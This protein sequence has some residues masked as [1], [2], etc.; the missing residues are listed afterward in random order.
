MGLIS[1][2]SSRTYRFP[3]KRPLKKSNMVI[4][5]SNKMLKK[6]NA[7][8]SPIETQIGQAVLDIQNNAEAS[9]K[10]QLMQLH[11]VGAKEFDVGGRNAI[12]ISVPAPQVPA[13]RKIQEKLVRELEKKFSNKHV[14]IVG[15]RKI[16]PE[17]KRKASANCYKQKRPISRSIKQVHEN[18]LE[19][20]V[21]PSIIIGKRIRH[22][23]DNKSFIK[24]FLNKSTQ[25]DT[26]HKTATFSA[27]YKRLTGKNVLFEFPEYDL[28]AELKSA[29]K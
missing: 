2:V 24:A 15:H 8:S 25:G 10:E 17:E 5:V 21:F 1:R 14:I 3:K 19:D 20:I 22:K 6:G 12:V 9:M 11:M 23:T 7:E 29:K 16:M 13:W 28:D 4:S 27:V 18:V 26:E